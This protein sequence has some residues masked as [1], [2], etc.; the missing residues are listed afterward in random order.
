MNSSAVPAWA[1]TSCLLCDAPPPIVA[2]ARATAATRWA[3]YGLTTNAQAS[4]A[5]L[6]TDLAGSWARDL[7]APLTRSNA[8]TLSTDAAARVLAVA[9]TVADLAGHAQPTAADLAEA[10]Q[11]RVG[12]QAEV[13]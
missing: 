12:E 4:A 2:Q 5:A 1:D 3:P 8:P 13:A 6:R 11:L 7:E 9:W 10:I